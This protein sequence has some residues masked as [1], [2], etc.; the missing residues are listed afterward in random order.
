M[1]EAADENQLLRQGTG[2]VSYSKKAT[3]D[4]SADSGEPPREKCPE[5]VTVVKCAITAIKLA[6]NGGVKG[7]IWRL[8]KLREPCSPITFGHENSV[9][10]LRR[11]HQ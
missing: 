6:C 8:P 4:T 3:T 1:G 2:C 7:R 11:R 9:K 5:V 10:V